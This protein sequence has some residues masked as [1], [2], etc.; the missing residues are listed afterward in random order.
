MIDFGLGLKKIYRCILKIKN[1]AAKQN[2]LI[3]GLYRSV[4]SLLESKRVIVKPL[5]GNGYNYEAI[6]V[7]NCLQNGQLESDVMPLDETLK[8]IEASDRIRSQWSE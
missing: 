5:K 7:I 3:R 1:L 8:I 2:F 4:S 6:E